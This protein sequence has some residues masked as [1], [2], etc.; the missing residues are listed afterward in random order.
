MNSFYTALL[1]TVASARSVVSMQGILRGLPLRLPVIEFNGA[2]LS[3]LATGRHETVNALSPS[4]AESVYAL[5]L[6]HNMVP[7][8]SSFDGTEDR[9]H[10]AAA[11]NAGMHWYLEDRRR[12]CDRRWQG[13]SSNLAAS[14][15]E[16]VVCLTIVAEEQP[17]AELQAAVLSAH[18][19]AVETHLFE[20]LYSPG[21]F[22]LTVHDCRA[23]KDQAI[24][25]LVQ[26]YGL[27]GC[28]IVVF[29]D[30][31]NDLKMF[32]LADRAV[33]VG[34][35]TEQLKSHAG[36]VIGPNESDSVVKFIQE[37]KKRENRVY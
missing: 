3:D 4:I 26:R 24:R 37:D 7:F 23:T 17:L 25:L 20:N 19:G 13:V 2:F 27:T 14:L 18:G 16:Q 35:A 15:R 28:E 31:S 6:R 9:V 1:F 8:V 30:G 11:A 21:W 29:G 12:H 36:V 32:Q 33:A 22:W 34:N 5:V 10:Y